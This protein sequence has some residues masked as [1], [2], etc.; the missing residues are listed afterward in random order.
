MSATRTDEGVIA[1]WS[2]FFDTEQEA[3]LF[4]LN[5]RDE[6]NEQEGFEYIE[7]AVDYDLKAGSWKLV[8]RFIDSR[9]SDPDDA[10]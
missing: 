9:P 7:H 4:G 3:Q 2:W 6:L 5:E 8:L 1:S 10:A